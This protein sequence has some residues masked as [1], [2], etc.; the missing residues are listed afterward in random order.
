MAASMSHNCLLTVS[1]ALVSGVLTQSAC[2]PKD[3]G[4]GNKQAVPPN[5]QEAETNSS[6][7]D[8]SAVLATIDGHEIRVQE[9]QD[10]INSQTPYVRARYTSNE[11]K[12]EFLDN[13]IRFE[14]LAMQAKDE[15][16]D[17]DPAVILSMKQLM[18][19]KLMKNRLE[20]GIR[21]EDILDSDMKA[22]YDDAHA[23]FNMPEEVRVAAIVLDTAGAAK[24][25]AVLALG[26]AGASNKGFRELVAL[27][28]V[29][30]DGKSRGGDLRYFTK[31]NGEI[32]KPVI[33]AAFGLKKT[34]DVA[35]PI[36]AGDGR[37]FIVKQTG[38]RKAVAKSYDEVKRQLQNRLYREK[39]T[40]AQQDFVE[41]LKNKA[42]IEINA[43]ALNQ[44]K[45]D[46]STAGL[47]GDPHR[48]LPAMPA[49]SSNSGQGPGEATR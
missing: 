49:P 17:K 42:T 11:Q 26:E 41:E 10:R 21:P 29:D 3:K 40:Q 38:H 20:K 46:T 37:F 18:V 14:I 28:S 1:L 34:G 30:K 22:A 8:T 6:K 16:F 36:D 5:G 45:I 7:S 2:T 4:K 27:H 31:D 47:P 12:R 24:S 48:N 19:Q 9:F 32:P 33:E 25:V 44:V 39:R 15:G 13:L 23:E 43:N 35:G